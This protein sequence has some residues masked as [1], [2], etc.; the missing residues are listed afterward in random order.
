MLNKDFL[1]FEKLKQEL[2]RIYGL[3]PEQ[4]FAVNKC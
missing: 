3:C 1:K 2:N 4:Y